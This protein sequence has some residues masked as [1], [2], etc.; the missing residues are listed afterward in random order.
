MTEEQ[1]AETQENEQP[2]G[3]AKDPVRQW[4]IRILVLSIV[5]LFVYVVADR[6]T[7]V[8]SQARVH[9][10]VVPIAS[11]VSGTVTEVDVQNNQV[12]QSGEVLFRLDDERYRVSVAGAE[13]S[14]QSARQ[15]TGASAAGVDA[16]EAAVRSAEAAF[17]RSE[18][19]AV[20]LRRI[21]AQDS[22]AISDRRIESAEA[23]LEVSQQQLAGARANLRQA[24]EKLGDSGEQNSGVQQAQAALENAQLN[25]ART[26][27]V[28][29][30]AG[31]VTDVRVNRGNFASAGAPQMTFISTEDVWVQA[32]FTEN[33]LGNVDRGD[34]V[35]V[36]FDVY[37]G[38]VFKG[39]VRTTGF[40][41]AVDSAPLGSLPTIQNNRQWL[42]DA[43]RFPVV[44][45]FE[46]SDEDM[47]RL[48]VGSQASVI[49]YATDNWFLNTLGR[50]YMRV[51]S[52]LSYAY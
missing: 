41:V 47:R 52:I 45:D 6:Y 50:L 24:Q 49:I 1:Q 40:G 48:K 10:L 34:T 33:N 27:V 21:K 44:V 43:Q 30:A 46:M 9:A 42:R 13:A 5:I 11:E 16:A 22:G 4:T 3:S 14:L 39:T 31:V 35:G 26:T 20:R 8:S 29:P 19:D 2:N 36:T 38:R 17:V 28:A 18:Q 15:A 7:P 25:L 32:D 23:S 51:G 12:V 37:P